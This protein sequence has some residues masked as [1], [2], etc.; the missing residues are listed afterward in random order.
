VLRLLLVYATVVLCVWLEGILKPK[1][2]SINETLDIKPSVVVFFNATQQ[3]LSRA[4][5]FPLGDG[6]SENNYQVIQE[7]TTMLV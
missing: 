1:I 4:A 6:D 5:P 7:M 2:E 3:Y